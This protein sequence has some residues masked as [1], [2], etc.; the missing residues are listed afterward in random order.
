MRSAGR[1]L[2]AL[3][4]I[5]SARRAPIFRNFSSRVVRLGTA[6]RQPS[7]GYLARHTV[8]FGTARATL[9]ARVAIGHF[10]GPLPPQTPGTP[11]PPH[12]AGIVQEP[13]SIALPQPSPAGPHSMCCSWHVCG[14]HD[15][16]PHVPGAPPPPHV[17]GGVHGPH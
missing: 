7:T 5:L 12:V 17:S 13:Q 3:A 2:L 1:A 11:P 16:R 6:R 15:C 10:G 14:V 4:F 8:G 9:A